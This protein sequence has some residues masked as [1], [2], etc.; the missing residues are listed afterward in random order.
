MRVCGGYCGLWR[1]GFRAVKERVLSLGADSL[2]RAGLW[3]RVE[4]REQFLLTL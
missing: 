3:L 2:C 1:R 4:V